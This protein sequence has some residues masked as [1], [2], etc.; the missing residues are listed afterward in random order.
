MI[1]KSCIWPVKDG[2]INQSGSFVNIHW[3]LISSY[4]SDLGNV[5]WIFLNESRPS[6]L[7]SW[8]HIWSTGLGIWEILYPRIPIAKLWKF[9]CLKER[10]TRSSLYSH[11]LPSYFIFGIFQYLVPSYTGQLVYMEFTQTSRQTVIVRGWD[12]LS[13]TRDEITNRTISFTVGI[14]FIWNK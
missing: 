14:N 2:V 10:I 11:I 5:D 13:L 9:T 12:W 8:Y 6:S 3:R 4:H 7:S 1:F